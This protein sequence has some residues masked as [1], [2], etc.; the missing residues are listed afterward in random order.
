MTLLFSRRSLNPLS[1][2]SS[3]KYKHCGKLRLGKKPKRRPGFSLGQEK[4]NKTKQNWEKNKKKKKKTRWADTYMRHLAYSG[5]R[6][7]LRY[8][9]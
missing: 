5:L 9:R 6:Q 8:S 4:Q 7:Y 2:S 1:W 3:R